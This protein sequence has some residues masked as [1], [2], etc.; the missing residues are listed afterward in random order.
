MGHPAMKLGPAPDIK[1]GTRVWCRSRTSYDQRK[2]RGWTHEPYRGWCA[3]VD[4]R[5]A[6]IAAEDVFTDRVKCHD[7]L[8]EDLEGV[9]ERNIAR[10]R[11][12]RQQLDGLKHT[13]TEN[14][15]KHIGR[16]KT[17]DIR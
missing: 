8:I 4:G 13:R 11:K 17:L 15:S 14:W 5:H 10:C 12:L 7:S 6:T 1:I 2:L 9:Y 3:I 16:V